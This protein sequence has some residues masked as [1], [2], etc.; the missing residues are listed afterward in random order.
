VGQGMIMYTG[1][2][3]VTEEELTLFTELLA[4]AGMLDRLPEN[5]I[6][7]G[8]AVSGCG[9]AFLCLLLEAMADGGV[10][11]GL[12]RQKAIAYAAQTMLGTAQTLLETGKHPGVFKDEVTSPGGST[13]AGVR[14]M[15]QEGVRA[16]MMDAVIAAYERNLEL[17]KK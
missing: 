5:L 9:P 1:A 16:A 17:G 13:I 12:P 6:D 4:P 10:A 2:E 7:A 15:E 14:A 3:D 8:T 11:C